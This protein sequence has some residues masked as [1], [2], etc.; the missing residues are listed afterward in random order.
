MS[1]YVTM[2]LV[3]PDFGC[4]NDAFLHIH[5]TFCPIE[6][7]RTSIGSYKREKNLRVMPYNRLYQW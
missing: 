2:S 5:L 7:G 6:Q 3:C 1:N 4:G